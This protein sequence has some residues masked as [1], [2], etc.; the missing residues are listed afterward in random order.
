M[1]HNF[2][3][4]NVQW[5]TTIPKPCR[6]FK[7]PH[8]CNVSGTVT[9]YQ[10]MIHQLIDFQTSLL[11]WVMPAWWQHSE[12]NST[13]ASLWDKEQHIESPPL[14][15]RRPRYC[16]LHPSVLAADLSS[17]WYWN[18]ILAQHINTEYMSTK[19]VHLWFKLYYF[20]DFLLVLRETSRKAGTY[21]CGIY[22]TIQIMWS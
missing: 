18:P 1:T 6:G 17:S 10:S 21:L 7:A 20:K 8:K 19:W 14:Q 4:M 2:L 9:P 11:S 3:W 22:I 13:S 16:H 5:G 12:S 15:E